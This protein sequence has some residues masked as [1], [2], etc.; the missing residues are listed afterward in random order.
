MTKEL[1]RILT[2]Y[3][4]C[5]DKEARIN[6]QI[7]ELE[8]RLMPSAIRYDKDKI[9]TSPIDPMIKIATEIADLQKELEEAMVQCRASCATA[10]K[11]INSLDD[12]TYD[13]G[14]MADIL[15][16]R[17]IKGKSWNQIAYD[18]H[19]SKQRC[20]QINSKAIA[21]LEETIKGQEWC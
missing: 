1:K 13:G 7:E 20:F 11:L 8:T 17:W 4:Y 16:M 18:M 10:T 19:Y 2:S 21:K 9:Q 5:L 6:Q 15:T 14:K 12:G 3:R